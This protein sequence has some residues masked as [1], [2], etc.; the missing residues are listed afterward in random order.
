MFLTAA[1]KGQKRRQ[2][3]QGQDF[4]HHFPLRRLGDRGAGGSGKPSA[5]DQQG[6]QIIIGLTPWFFI[7]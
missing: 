7:W 4:L 6:Y 1:G 5:G 2:G 3:K